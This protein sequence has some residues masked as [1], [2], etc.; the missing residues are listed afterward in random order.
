MSYDPSHRK[1][2][3][4]SGRRAD[5][6]TPEA[7]PAVEGGEGLRDDG[8]RGAA[9]WDD[10]P[11]GGADRSHWAADGYRGQAGNDWG[12]GET[13]VQNES[14]G[15]GGYAE[16]RAGT[17]GWDDWAMGGTSHPTA[18]HPTAGHPASSHPTAG[19]PR[20]GYPANGY[21]T[22]GYP[23]A[24]Y[25]AAG[26]AD[27]GHPASGYPTN[28]YAGPGQAAPGY[29]GQGYPTNGYQGTGYAGS[30]YGTAGYPAADHPGAGYPTAGYP[31]AGYPATDYADP[32]DA[33]AGDAFAGDAFG[34]AGDGYRGAYEGF[35]LDRDEYGGDGYGEA[36]LAD[37]ALMPPDTAP[38]PGGWRGGRREAEQ[39][40]LLISAMTGFL[41]AAMAIG[42]ATLAAAFVRPQASP[43]ISVGAVVNRTPSALKEL[44]IQR[45]GEHDKTMLLVG[46]AIAIALIAMGIGLL[47]RRAAALGVA[48]IAAFGLFGAFAVISRPASRASDVIPSIVGGIVGAAALVWLARAS[49]PPAPY[50]VHRRAR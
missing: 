10:G 2:P 3:R 44:A 12:Q 47:S 9:P 27:N 24:G 45:F 25:A 1:P 11:R 41:A 30:G 7:W 38:G 46:M 43:V 26:Y 49:A 31:T 35:G 4:H 19:L 22:N 40:G 23:A 20:A 8:P 36:F 17:G 32:G 29:A 50:S 33:F 15:Q 48:G 37:P 34:E 16:G 18:G 6:M 21:P 42:V 39:R 5:V 14:W 13:W 28:G